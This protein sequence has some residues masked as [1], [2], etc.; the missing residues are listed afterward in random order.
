MNVM[1]LGSNGM[2]GHM[3]AKFLQSKK[4]NVRTVSRKNADIKFDLFDYSKLNDLIENMKEYDFIINCAGCLVSESSNSLEKALYINSYVPRLISAKLANAK[5]KIVH[6]ST[7]CVFNGKTSANY[8][9]SDIPNE[10]GNYGLSK[11]MGEINNTKDITFRLSKI[12]PETPNN[13]PGIL[14]WFL[15]ENSETVSGWTNHYWN[16]I[17]TLELARL[18]YIHMKNP[19]SNGIYALVDNDFI[20]TKYELICKFKRVFNQAIDIIPAEHP[21]TTRKVLNNPFQNPT[22]KVKD[23]EKQLEDLKDYLNKTNIKYGYNL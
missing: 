21:S 11:M 15:R 19:I 1:I 5:T 12:G 7:D 9:P 16:G 4:I 10:T 23:F 20:C 18:I 14:D 6:L 2:N 22:L 13:T 17:T 8:L 3:I